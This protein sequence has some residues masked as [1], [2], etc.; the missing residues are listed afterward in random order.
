VLKD[1]SKT[2]QD[3]FSEALRTIKE[4]VIKHT[5]QPI[6]NITGIQLFHGEEEENNEEDLRYG[7]WCCHRTPAGTV[8]HR[9]P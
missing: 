6:E 8:C 4:L 5:N 1:L 7:H 3:A 2:D 9:C